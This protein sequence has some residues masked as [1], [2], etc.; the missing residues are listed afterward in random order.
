M[1][2]LTIRELINA[3]KNCGIEKE[4]GSYKAVMFDFCTGLG[5]A[6]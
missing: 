2:T 3:V 4:D 5:M 1:E 6:M